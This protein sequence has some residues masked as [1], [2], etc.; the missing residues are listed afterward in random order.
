MASAQTTA[1][2][3]VEKKFIVV[4]VLVSRWLLLASRR[5]VSLNRGVLVS[6]NFE[7]IMLDDGIHALPST[8]IGGFP[9]EVLDILATIRRSVY[10][11]CSI[12]PMGHRCSILRTRQARLLALDTLS[13]FTFEDATPS[14]VPDTRILNARPVYCIPMLALRTLV[15]R[16]TKA[17]SNFLSYETQYIGSSSCPVACC[18]EGT[19]SADVALP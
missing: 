19:R 12:Y 18:V 5:T 4:C 14:S 8:T 16:S 15:S 2:L 7:S 11:W 17:S 13:D 6:G 3:N 9:G 1:R 10:L